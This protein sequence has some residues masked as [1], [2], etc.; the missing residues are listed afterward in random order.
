MVN[1]LASTTV[2]VT[3]L[4]IKYSSSTLNLSTEKF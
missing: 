4:S 2:Q 3:N 1:N